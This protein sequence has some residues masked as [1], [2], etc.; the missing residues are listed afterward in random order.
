MLISK[1]LL[2]RIITSALFVA[3]MA[4]AWD[5]WW[6]A[7]VGRDSFW[8]APH[9]VLYSAVLV[10]ILLGVYG[11]IK[12]KEKVWKYLAI[13]LLL[14]PF[15]APFDD[16]WHRIYGVEDLSSPMVIWS[17]PHLVLVL[18]LIASFFLLLPHLRKDPDSSAKRFFGGLAFGGIVSLSTLLVAPLE[19]TGPWHLLGFFGSGFTAF[20]L[21]FILLYGQ[22]WMKGVARATFIV[23][24]IILFQSIGGSEQSA[25]GIIIPPHDHAPKWLHLFSL[26]IP[27]AIIDLLHKKSPILK[28]LVFALLW[29]GLLYGFSSF[30]FD[31]EFQ[32][33]LS[34]GMRAV[35]VSGIGGVCAGL[36]VE[37]FVRYN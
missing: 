35:L 25:P 3:A 10:A 36:L 37:R 13:A 21:S 29:S 24:F 7:A 11:Y 27:A 1:I 2:P 23:I 15:A 18:T 20:V 14:I 26:L 32:Y 34:D 4:G 33:T 9:L 17:P 28:G 5:A 30:F 16:L 19:P 31:P 22:K 12:N 6:H 8:E